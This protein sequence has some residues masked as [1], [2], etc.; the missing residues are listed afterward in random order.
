MVHSVSSAHR[1]FSA[2]SH[3]IFSKRPAP[4]LFHTLKIL[5]SIY[6]FLTALVAVLLLI[7]GVSLFDSLCH[8]MTTVSTG[9]YSPYDASIDHF[10]RAGYRHYV[11]IEYTVLFGMVLGGMNFFIHYRVATGGIKA[12]WDN[13]ETR[14]YWCFLAGATALVM[15]DRFAK[16][17][18]D[19]AQDTFRYS[20]FQVVSIM[21]ST[22]FA[23]KDIGTSYFPALAKQVLLVLMVV[24]GC[25]GST[26][27]GFKVL[28]V[29]ILLRMLGR[30][31]RRV[32]YGRTSV[33]LVTVDGQPIETEELRRIAALFF[34]WI[35]LLAIGAGV[36]ALLSEHRAIESASGMFSA[37]G[38][39]GPCYISTG[40]LTALHPVI[41][42]TYIL[43][44][45]AG[46]L[47]ILPILL[48]FTRRTWR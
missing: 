36:T 46:R 38:N 23:T 3:K 29:G 12:L 7:E 32:I 5:W 25:V 17:G 4:G 15:I 34:A 2:E 21:T 35:M 28:R 41:K 19:E 9:G 44:M 26:S 18:F 16:F 20:A 42:I 8:S 6:A 40:D 47:E 27:G 37:L 33:N 14:L 1:L 22:G 11:L 31:L 45:L 39:I 43:G 10:R 30:Q 48:L 13:T 24:G